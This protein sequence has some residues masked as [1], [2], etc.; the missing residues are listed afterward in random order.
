M[1]MGVGL[2]LFQDLGG[3]GYRLL[4]SLDVNPPVASRDPH[5][6]RIADSPQV[7]VTGAEQ[8]QQCLGTDNR[9]GCLNH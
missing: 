3:Q 6:Q 7:L 4:L 1:A 9:N 5:P 8:R 2:K